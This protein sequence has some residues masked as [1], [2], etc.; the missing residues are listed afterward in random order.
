M[1]PRCPNAPC[2]ND[3]DK[4]KD[5]GKASAE[6]AEVFRKI[7]VLRDKVPQDI[8]CKAQAIGA[9][10][11]VFNLAFTFGYR[12]GDGAI[13]FRTPNGWSSPVFF[14][15]KGGSFG[16]QIGAQSTDYLLVFMSQ[17]SVKDLSDGEFD[18][19]LDANAVIGPVFGARAQA[20]SA[21]FPKSKT[22]FIYARSKGAFVGAY[23]DG[24]KLMARNSVNEEVYGA[25][26]EALL[27]NP[28]RLQTVATTCLAQGLCDLPTTVA[29]NVPN[30]VP[31]VQP[32]IFAQPQ[33]A[34][35]PAAEAKPA[36]SE[37]PAPKPVIEVTE[38]TVIIEEQPQP[39]PKRA[40]K[41]RRT[42]K[43]KH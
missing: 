22:V 1:A 13:T 32:V 41:S 12:Q 43:M 23:L 28:A 37:Q 20:G 21:D 33:P 18:L 31:I 36:P 4:V 24:A 40:T 29:T 14:K 3:C 38:E 27:S 9:F 5:A 39:Q 6:A 17:E 35:A 34:P 30:P 42:H 10:S 19:A 16:W 11:G 15:M 7:S 2:L 8:L 26:A 25:D